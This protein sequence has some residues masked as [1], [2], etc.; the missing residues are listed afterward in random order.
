MTKPSDFI[1]NSDFLSIAQISS[2][3]LTANFSG[4]TLSGGDY[5]ERTVDFSVAAQNGAIDNIMLSKDGGNYQV[6]NWQ[7]LEIAPND[8]EFKRIVGFI[9]VYRINASTL[10]A[11][12]VLENVSPNA[13]DY[14]AMT[15]KIKVSSFKPPNVF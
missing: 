7:R 2:N 1:L 8:S 10:R 15:Y 14:P 4:G 6:G 5:I 3:T 11:Q 12:M 9:S 13:L